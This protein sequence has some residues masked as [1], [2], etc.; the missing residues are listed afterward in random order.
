MGKLF[1]IGPQKD[2][3]VTRGE[4]LEEW[5][6]RKRSEN[7][8]NTEAYKQDTMSKEEEKPKQRFRNVTVTIGGEP[9]NG[10]STI[11]RLF[12]A[13]CEEHGLNYTVKD[14]TGKSTFPPLSEIVAEIKDS[15]R[16]NVK[17]YQDGGRYEALGSVKYAEPRSIRATV[18]AAPRASGEPIS[19]Q[20]IWA[21]E[22]E[23]RNRVLED[24]GPVGPSGISGSPGL[25]G[26]PIDDDYD[27]MDDFPQIEEDRGQRPNGGWKMKMPPIGKVA[28]PDPEEV[29]F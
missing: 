8:K 28:N 24:V 27:P 23:G 6:E 7:I 11:T 17:T 26:A 16:I 20:A 21:N 15:V 1:G 25:V 18:G 29:Q 2:R 10:K 4:T 5:R 19:Y 9:E 3:E 14:D 13:F 12:A 22:I